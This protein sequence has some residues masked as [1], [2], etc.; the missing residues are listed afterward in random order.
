MRKLIGVMIVALIIAVVAIPASAVEINDVKPGDPTYNAV[1][2]LVERGYLP[3]YQGG[4]FSGDKPVDRYTIASVIAKLLSDIEEG[5]IYIEGAD[6]EILKELTG[7]FRKE[8]VLL[9]EETGNIKFRLSEAE[10]TLLILK[11]DMAETII[12]TE[13]LRKTVGAL[14]DQLKSLREDIDIQ[15]A[16]QS[17]AL[18]SEL[19]KVK[20]EFEEYKAKTEKLLSQKDVDFAAYQRRTAAE[21]RRTQLYILGAILIGIVF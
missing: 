16:D 6:A 2:T 14:E 20:T 5:K 11:E 1:K 18:Q 17:K 9:S 21:L 10:R 12:N 7:E 8:L 19:T 3:L 15:Q 13:S 4:L